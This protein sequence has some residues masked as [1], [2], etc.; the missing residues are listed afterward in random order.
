MDMEIFETQESDELDA[1]IK[2]IG[3]YDGSAYNVLLD[4]SVIEDWTPEEFLTQ[5]RKLAYRMN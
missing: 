5:V 4:A 1:L 3:G 2:M